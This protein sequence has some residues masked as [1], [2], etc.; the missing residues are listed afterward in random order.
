MTFQPTSPVVWTE[1]PVRDLK[2]GMDFYGTVFGYGFEVEEGGPNPL[3]TFRYD[4]GTGTSGHLYP[5]TPAPD[6]TGPTV[7]LI[8]PDKLEAA[9]ER[10]SAAGGT[11]LGPVLEIPPG[12]FQYAKDP[13]GNSIGLFEP[14]AA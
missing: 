1:I 9:A 7:H 6:G 13:D 5:G 14:K 10:C 11:L 2:A 3:A 4:E 12:R 8:V